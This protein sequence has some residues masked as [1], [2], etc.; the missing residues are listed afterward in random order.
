MLP[1]RLKQLLVGHVCALALH[2]S[3][4]RLR[5]AALAEAA[6]MPEVALVKH[7]KEMGCT[8]EKL[9]KGERSEEEA[10]EEEEE[11]GGKKGGSSGQV[12]VLKMPLK[13]PA[14][15]L[16]RRNKKTQAW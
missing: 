2:A 4:F 9:R 1:A 10:E 15:S 14:A 13:F 12:V 16:G 5:A 11:G 7:C 6:G 3:G 8:V